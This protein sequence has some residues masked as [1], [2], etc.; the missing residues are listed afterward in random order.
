MKKI[1]YLSC[2][3]ILEYDE[4]KL[5]SELG[6]NVRSIGSYTNPHSPGDPKRPPIFTMEVVD[7]HIQ[8][9]NRFH[10]DNLHQEQLDWADIIICMHMPDWILTQTDKLKIWNKPIIWRSIGQSSISVEAQ[11][12]EMKFRHGDQ[13]KIIRYS[14][15]EAYIDTNNPFYE[16]DLIRF[17]KDQDELK[18]VWP[19]R[20]KTNDVLFVTQAASR[21]GNHCH[22]DEVNELLSCLPRK[23]LIGPDN[24]EWVSSNLSVSCPEYP[25]LKDRYA[26]S[27]VFVY[28][29]TVP[30]CYTLAPME[31]MM[32]GT[33]ILTIN[34]DWWAKGH[35]QWLNSNVFEVPLWFPDQVLHTP[36]VF[37]SLN[38]VRAKVEM[39]IHDRDWQLRASE[40]SREVALR[41]FNKKIAQQSW[42]NLL[43]SL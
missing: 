5:L 17:Y 33:P 14:P 40:N 26:E 42:S 2:H 28:T 23:M 19:D 1:L 29:G 36:S 43:E 18:H 24:E 32:V 15:N 38:E 9:T 10:Q 4:C 34:Q 21:R 16:D 7:S 11:I 37:D 27:T 30:A 25:V 13:I 20:F 35:E 22:F 3:A 8:V 39:M 31:A 41:L 6:Y 12:R